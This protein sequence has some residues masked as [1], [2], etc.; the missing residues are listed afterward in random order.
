MV[1]M[2]VAA[3]ALAV[4]SA[5]CGT[6]AAKAPLVANGDFEKGADGWTL[7]PG[8]SFVK[9]EGRSMTTALVY[10]N[11]DPDFPYAQPKQELKLEPGKV[12]RFSAWIRTED[13]TP[14]KGAGASVCLESQDGD[15]KTMKWYWTTGMKGSG[16][17][18]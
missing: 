18:K 8:Y 13:I 1:R 2:R 5:L 17:W 6:V 11:R 10:E 7:T 14:Q 12:Y 4:V 15:G 16:D 3:V 9:G